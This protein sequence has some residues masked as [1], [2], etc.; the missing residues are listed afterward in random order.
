M[1]YLGDTWGSKRALEISIGLMLLPSFLIG[2]LP[3]YEVSDRQKQLASYLPLYL[4][5]DLS[6]N[7][8]TYPICL[9]SYEVGYHRQKQLASYLPLYLFI[10]LSTNPTTYPIC[11][12]SYEVGYHRQKQLASLEN[13]AS[14]LQLRKRCIYLSANLSTYL[15][16]TYLIIY[17]S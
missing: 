16:T 8:T 5:I 9:P 1:G 7:P 17:L 14:Q 10:D 4:F 2:C 3:S 11:L 13:I 6:T 12:P 15:S